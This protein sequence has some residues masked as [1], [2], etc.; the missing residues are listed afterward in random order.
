MSRLNIIFLIAFVGLLIWI[1]LFQP[2]AVSTIQRGA[3]VAFRPF[4][5]ASS[6]VE[7]ALG[8]LGSESLSPAQMRA[9]LAEVESDRDRLQLEVIQLDEL[10]NENNQLRRALLYKEKSPLELIAARVINRK[11][12]NWY[13]TLVIDKGS[14]DGVEVDSPVIVPVGE[15]AGLVGKITEVIGDHSAVVLL[16]TDEMCQVSAKLV[17]SQEQGILNG[18]R[19]ALQTLPNLRLR[20]LSKEANAEAGT[21]VMS[22]GTGELFPANLYL[23]EIISIESGVIDSE[24][25]VRPGVDFDSLVDV[26]IILPELAKEEETSEPEAVEPAVDLEAIDAPAE[27]KL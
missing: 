1:T 19:G 11:P 6:E 17:K 24:A 16:L 27:A 20:Y 14:L 23:G 13:N 8:T 3:M 10:I 25:K 4:I 12:S 2:E 21:K 7:G 26:F 5:R 9:K 15:E 18:Q 22:S